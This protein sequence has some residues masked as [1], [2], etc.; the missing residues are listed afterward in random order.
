MK[1]L[2]LPV[3]LTSTMLFTGC[4]NSTIEKE[5]ESAVQEA[6]L[7]YEYSNLVDENT[8]NRVLDLMKT[9]GLDGRTID[10]FMKTVEDY[11]SKQG[12][13]DIAPH[14]FVS[15]NTA[16]APYDENQLFTG[17]E[18]LQLPYIDLNCRITSFMLMKDLVDSGGTITEESPELIFDLNAIENNPNA[19]MS[20][21]DQQKFENIF[22]PISASETT[23]VKEHA[24][25]IV[26]EWVKRGI[27]FDNDSTSWV[28]VFLHYPETENLFIGHS[29]VLLEEGDG[30][31]FIEKLAQTMPFQVSKFKTKEELYHVLMQRYDINTGDYAKIAS[32]PIIMEND[33]LFNR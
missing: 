27:S 30:F 17:W 15:I 31:L 3:L 22:Y 4:S 26:K 24:K 20:K 21:A 14:G 19:K 13:E 6:A 25:T 8:Q 1:N 29:G 9:R 5:T 11:N 16:N 10:W 32:K 2:L 18:E 33:K 28:N 23:D 12:M 7:S